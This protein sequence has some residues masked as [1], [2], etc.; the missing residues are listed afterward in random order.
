[1]HLCI[2]IDTFAQSF[3]QRTA[4]GLVSGC[5]PF[6]PI[7]AQASRRLLFGRRSVVNRVAPEQLNMI[8]HAC[9]RLSDDDPSRDRLF[10]LL[11]SKAET[12]YADCLHRFAMTVDG[13]S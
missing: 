7:R 10:D 2:R 6:A 5:C 13:R 1:M 8:Y 12:T 11:M 3:L 4:N 9:R